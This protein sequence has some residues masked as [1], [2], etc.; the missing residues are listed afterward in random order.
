[1]FTTRPPV[2]IKKPVPSAAPDAAVPPHPPGLDDRL[3]PFKPP[4]SEKPK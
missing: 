4:D 3:N 1:V 2:V